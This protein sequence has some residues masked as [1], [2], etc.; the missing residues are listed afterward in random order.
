M[1]GILYLITKLLSVLYFC[2]TETDI[3]LAILVY[4]IYTV[5]G[6]A[7]NIMHWPHTVKAAK[8]VYS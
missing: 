6:I 2:W 3:F 5:T 8:A 1:N 4:S 7:P